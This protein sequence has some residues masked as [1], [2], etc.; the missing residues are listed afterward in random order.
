[1]AAGGGP[2]GDSKHQVEGEKTFGKADGGEDPQWCG[3]PK[4]TGDGGM[5]LVQ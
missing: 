3:S 5:P 1:V 4:G 2:G